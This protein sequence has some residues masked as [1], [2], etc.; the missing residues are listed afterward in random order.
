MNIGGLLYESLADGSGVR[1][2]IFLS[3][4]F[5]KC[6]GCHNQQLLDFNY[7]VPFD[8]GIQRCVIDYIKSNPLI[9]GITISGGDPMFSWA[10]LLDFLKD[11]NEQLPSCN[12][13]LYTGFTFEDIKDNPVMQY[14]DVL[15]DGTYKKDRP[16]DRF[17]GSD[18]QRIIDVKKTLDKDKIILWKD[19]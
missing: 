5:H 17:V 12:I 8:K 10:K 6:E 9:R 2:V 3:G 7:G 15:V 1:T 13:W 4:C 19:D 11:V 18:N 14:I 16:C